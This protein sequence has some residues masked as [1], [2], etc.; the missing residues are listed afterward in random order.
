M[1]LSFFK[2][3]FSIFLLTTLAL[4]LHS[5]ALAAPKSDAKWKVGLFG[6]ST[7]DDLS[8]SRVVGVAGL[9]RLRHEF[10]PNLDALFLG[11]VV[12]ETGSSSSLFTD[13]YEPSTRMFLGEASIGW[14]I[15]EPFQIRA[16]ALN[17]SH[18]ASPL[19]LDGGTFPAALAVLSTTNEVGWMARFDVQAAIPTSKRLSTKN[20]GKE[21]IPSLF[22]QKIIAGWEGAP[23]E[24]SFLA[25]A[26]HF[27]FQNLTRGMAQDSRFYG[28]TINGIGS[29]SRFVYQYQGYEAGFDSR[30]PLGFL[31]LAGLGGSFLQNLDGPKGYDQGQYGY[32]DLQWSFNTFRLRPRVEYYRN[33]GDS[34][35]AFYSSSDFGHNN[36]KGYGASLKLELP[37]PGLDIE[38]RARRARLIEPR[39]FQRDRFDYLELTVEIPYVGF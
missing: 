7:D 16:G 35:P 20:T 5:F 38:L 39:T 26:T 11:G 32:A 1:K 28:N 4:F 29:G 18:H 10:N 31:G 9:I 37:N 21:D 33:E 34:S 22:T 23:E 24:F 19:Y 8:S 14:R 30:I 3:G 36:R 6:R 15:F 25:R 27:E 2:T 12:L 13:E 17:Q